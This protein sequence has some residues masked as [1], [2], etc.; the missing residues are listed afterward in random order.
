MLEASMPVV[1]VVHIHCN[2]SCDY[3]TGNAGSHMI[4]DNI[5]YVRFRIA[6]HTVIM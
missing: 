4:S 6:I 5:W 2:P 1:T 3:T